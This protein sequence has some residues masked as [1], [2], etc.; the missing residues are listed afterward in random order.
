[1]GQSRGAVRSSSPVSFSDEIADGNN[2]N[3]SATPDAETMPAA[4]AAEGEGE[5]PQDVEAEVARGFHAPEA[6]T[7]AEK[8]A[9][10]R[11]HLP[12][13]AWCDICVQGRGKLLHTEPQMDQQTGMP[14]PNS[15]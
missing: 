12:F 10:D 14:V 3:S 1:M 8:E 2:Q 4:V 9:H 15:I 13:R 5:L 7:K 11:T 6:P